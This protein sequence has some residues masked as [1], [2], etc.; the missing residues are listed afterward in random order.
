MASSPAPI[1]VCIICRDGA[2][3]LPGC[4]KSVKHLASEILVVV[5]PRTTDAT[6]QIAASFGAT[7]Y[8][9][10]FTDFASQ[11]N[12]ALSRAAQPWVL[13][14][15]ADERLSPQLVSEINRLRLTPDSQPVGY[16]IPRRNII[17]G[18]VMQHTNWDPRS[19]AHLWL[20]RADSGI[21]TGSVH[22][23]VQITGPTSRLIHPKIHYNYATVEDY[24]V[25]LNHYTSFEGRN[26]PFSLFFLLVLPLW[27]FVRHFVVY[28]GFKD[29]WHGLFLSY[30]QAIYG[31]TAQ[32][33]A[34]E[35]SASA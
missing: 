27:K 11:K 12:Y 1:S 20:F 32:V 34:W 24:F 7:V 8:D 35:K 18:R 33:K 23:H 6:R 9:H 19:D 14:L 28:S 31:L 15:D 21:W 29:G 13:F 16:I 2:H 22:E 4:L 5:D 30:L 10:P 26:R 25:K 3:I 17:F